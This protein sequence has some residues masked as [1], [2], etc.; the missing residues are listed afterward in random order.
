MSFIIDS[1]DKAKQE[2]GNWVTLDGSEFCIAYARNT[3]FIKTLNRLRKPYQRQLDKGTLDPE[4]ADDIFCEALAD[5]ILVDWKDVIDSAGNTIP[6]SKEIAKQA[7]V[8]NPE[9]REFVSE[10]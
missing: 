6:Y 2:D 7:L 3:R 8:G 9:L 1:F 10:Y 5:A 4:T